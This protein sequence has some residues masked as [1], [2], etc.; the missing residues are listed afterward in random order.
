MTT[1]TGEGSTCTEVTVAV[2]VTVL[3]AVV[4]VVVVLV[5]GENEDD[6][7]VVTV[8]TPV[9]TK[10][11]QSLIAEFTIISDFSATLEALSFVIVILT[12][13]VE[14]FMLRSMT[15]VAVLNVK[16]RAGAALTVMRL[17]LGKP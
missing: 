2:A 13:V 17:P 11:S 9:L 15:N 16:L 10:K 8:D 14:S 1:E 12:V 5:G 3:V 6:V 4:I 7:V